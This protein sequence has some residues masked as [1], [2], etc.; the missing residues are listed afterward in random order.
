MECIFGHIFYWVN[1]ITAML[2][3]LVMICKPF[4]SLIVHLFIK[5]E[6]K[7]NNRIDKLCDEQELLKNGIKAIMHDRIFQSCEYFLR[8]NEISVNELENLGKLYQPYSDLGGNGLCERLYTRVQ[9][10]EVKEGD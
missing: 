4:R 3:L 8:Q 6:S 9:N 1:G 10:L 7:Q 5:P 2:V